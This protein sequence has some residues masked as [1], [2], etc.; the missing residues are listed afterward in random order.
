[1]DISSL[2]VQ[3]INTNE[4][5]TSVLFVSSSFALVKV[6]I[7]QQCLTMCIRHKKLEVNKPKH[8]N[9]SKSRKN[10]FCNTL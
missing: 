6:I 3:F 9:A 1:M 5:P 4:V 10:K 2:L 7:I 8:T